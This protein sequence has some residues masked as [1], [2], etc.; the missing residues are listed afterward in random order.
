MTT[1]PI[2]IIDDFLP[3]PNA[4]KNW[5]LDL[6][7]PLQG[8]DRYPGVRSLD[9]GN[10][11]PSF[12]KYITKKINSIF[13]EET[14][15]IKATGY[16]QNIT[17][18]PETGWIHQDPCLYTAILYLSPSDPNIDRGTSLYDLK[19][20]TFFGVRNINDANVWEIQKR[21]Y[22]NNFISPEDLKIKNQYENEVFDLKINI[23]DKFNRLA[24][25][26]GDIYH[27]NNYIISPNV[28]DR[29]TLILFFYKIY[30]SNEYPILRSKL[31]LEN[32][33]D[34]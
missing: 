18:L 26:P 24:V 33:I 23:P 19:P 32:P 14:Q 27:A 11:H 28:K 17:S 5:A 3:N 21:H 13:F 34:F 22:L 15:G 2:T 4:T 12:Y 30:T 20:N 25:F 10:I 7:Y 1:V 8:K 6:E 31:T 16:F 29:L 9:L